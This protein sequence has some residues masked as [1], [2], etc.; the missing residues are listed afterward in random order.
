M[1]EKNKNSRTNNGIYRIIDANFNRSKEGL[2]VVEDFVR[3]ALDNKKLAS[4]IKRI[5]HQIDKI[6]RGIYPKIVFSRNSKKDVF[7]TVKESRKK[8]GRSIVISNIKRVE[9][10][11]RVL[12]E[13]SKMISAT[14]GLKI[15]KVRFSV[16]DIEKKVVEY[17]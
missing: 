8:T 10:S 2:R 7:R 16:Y 13:F 5:R 12:E 9:E 15:K 3:F 1:R 14:A 17:F 4:C 6:A 11:L